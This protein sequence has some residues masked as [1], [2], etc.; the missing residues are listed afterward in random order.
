MVECGREKGERGLLGR[1]GGK[2]LA[3]QASRG[4]REEISGRKATK[5][6]GKQE[7]EGV[8]NNK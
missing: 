3:R 5:E 1:G 6:E 2:M 8:V 7:G 4:G